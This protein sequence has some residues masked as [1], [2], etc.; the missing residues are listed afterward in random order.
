MSNNDT[1]GECLIDNNT[2]GI[3]NYKQLYYLIDPRQI[4]MDKIIIMGH[5]YKSGRTLLMDS[6]IILLD[7]DSLLNNNVILLDSELLLMD[8][9]I[10]LLDRKSLIYND[11]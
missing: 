7:I 5:Q 6:N 3:D 4:L 8:S 11:M 9:N 1:I 10:K 2:V